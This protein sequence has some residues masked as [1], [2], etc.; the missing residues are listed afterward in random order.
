[1]EPSVVATVRPPVEPMILLLRPVQFICARVGS[2][3]KK[4]QVADGSSVLLRQK[5]SDRLLS[6]RSNGAFALRGTVSSPRARSVVDK[7]TPSTITGN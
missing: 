2:R 5:G 6:F 3:L 1:M 4:G 7:N